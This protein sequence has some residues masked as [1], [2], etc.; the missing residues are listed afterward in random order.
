MQKFPFLTLKQS[1]LLLRVSLAI[2][3]LAHAIVRLIH[4][5][6]P[7]FAA[8]MH[9][10][11]FPFAD[12]I[13]WMITIFEIAGSIALALN[14]CVKWLSAAFIVLLVAGIFIIHLPLG[15]FVG[16]HGTGGCEYSFIL[17]MCFVVVVANE[18]KKQE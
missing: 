13:V 15:W 2:I 16:E 8:A 1:M 12:A 11:G 4:G 17:I 18:E 6:I 5:T 9:N 14:Y 10:K 7:Q 3:F